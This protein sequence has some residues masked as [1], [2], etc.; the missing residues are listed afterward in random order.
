MAF[1]IPRKI[2]IFALVRELC[3]NGNEKRR[4][5]VFLYFRMKIES[6]NFS[7]FVVMFKGSPDGCHKVRSIVLSGHVEQKLSKYNHP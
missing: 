6:L 3:I 4:K 1:G 7:T 5:K 2:Y